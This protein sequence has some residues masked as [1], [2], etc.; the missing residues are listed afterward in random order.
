MEDTNGS[1]L[2]NEKKQPLGSSPPV[3][4]EKMVPEKKDFSSTIFVNHG[5]IIFLN[6]SIQNL[7]LLIV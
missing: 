4:E 7:C 6:E 1:S 5:D 3:D 2:S